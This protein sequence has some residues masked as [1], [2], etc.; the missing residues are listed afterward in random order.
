MTEKRNADFHYLSKRLSFENNDVPPQPP[1]AEGEDISPE[2]R[3]DLV[4]TEPGSQSLSIYETG[5]LFWMVS[6]FSD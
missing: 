6:C 4:V 2:P 3:S 5:V 1:I